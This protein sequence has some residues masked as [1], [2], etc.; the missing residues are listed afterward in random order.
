MRTIERGQALA[1]ASAS[2]RSRVR[3]A[4]KRPRPRT[5]GLHPIDRLQV[6]HRILDA[7]RQLPHGRSSGLTTWADARGGVADDESRKRLG[8]IGKPQGQA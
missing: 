1:P 6:Q 3:I 2:S 4:R 7:R 8:R 5:D